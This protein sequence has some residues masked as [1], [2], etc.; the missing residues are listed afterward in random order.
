[1]SA[2]IGPGGGWVDHTGP[3]RGL[4]RTSEPAGSGRRAP[5]SIVFRGPREIL[6]PQRIYRSEH[7]KFEIFELFLVSIGPDQDGL[8]YEAI[9][10]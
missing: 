1:M 7:E 5:F 6:L 3:S 2:A 4:S 9:V 10:T 8:R